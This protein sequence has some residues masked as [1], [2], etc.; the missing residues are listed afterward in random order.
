MS[1]SL[2][3][4]GGWGRAVIILMADLFINVDKI[5]RSWRV[6]NFVVLLDMMEW[7]YHQWS[8]GLKV[9]KEHF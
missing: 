1:G 7:S 2:G 4:E 6:R 9:S 3:A 5:Q 8:F